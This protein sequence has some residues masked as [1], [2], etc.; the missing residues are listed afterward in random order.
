M[1][2]R[3]EMIL[4]VTARVSYLGVSH[5]GEP[6]LSDQL[7]DPG[8]LLGPRDGAGQ[9]QRCGEAQV[10]PDRERAHHHIVLRGVRFKRGG[11]VSKGSYCCPC[12]LGS[13]CLCQPTIMFMF[14]FRIYISTT[15]FK[16]NKKIIIQEINHLCLTCES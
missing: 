8:L 3:T 16:T 15:T 5:L 2:R 6:Q 12:M 9:P 13:S 7:A 14:I 4:G 10:L 11:E 1:S